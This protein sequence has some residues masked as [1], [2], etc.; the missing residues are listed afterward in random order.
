MKIGH[1][2]YLRGLAKLCLAKG[3]PPPERVMEALGLKESDA[4]KPREV[5][6]VQ[7][8]LDLRSRPRQR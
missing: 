7:Q 4:Y 1:P 5:K 3:N 2:G 6:K 8:D